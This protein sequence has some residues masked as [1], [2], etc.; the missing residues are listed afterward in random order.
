[1]GSDAEHRA[2]RASGEPEARGKELQ[3]Q[4]TTD[5]FYLPTTHRTHRGRHGQL[6]GA[7]TEGALIC[8]CPCSRSVNMTERWT[9]HAVQTSITSCHL[10]RKSAL[11]RVIDGTGRAVRTQSCPFDSEALKTLTAPC[12]AVHKLS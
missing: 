4:T 6:Q 8:V 12:A 7:A 5:T 1:M 3:I 2:C 11:S 10:E 9:R